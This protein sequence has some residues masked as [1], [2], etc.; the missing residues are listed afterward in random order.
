MKRKTFFVY[1]LAL[2]TAFLFCGAFCAPEKNIY[3]TFDDGPS[4]KITPVILDILAEQNIKATFFVIGKN[5]ERNPDVLKRIFAEG[6]V[7]GIH[8]Y[9]HEYKKIYRDERALLDDIEKCENA[10]RKINPAFSSKL[11]RFPGGS[12][13][14]S[15]RFTEAVKSRGYRYVDWNASNGDCE[16]K[17]TDGGKELAEYAIATGGKRGTIIMLM[18]D[19]AGKTATAESLNEII[20]HYKKAG[21]A[22]KTLK[23]LR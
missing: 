23:T 22:F 1:F 18:H 17:D 3:L 7:V 6:H 5:A 8:S 19:A 16:I 21:Y 20:G 11:Y 14:L 12:F 10:I 9:T 15:E 13:G 2:L 4:A